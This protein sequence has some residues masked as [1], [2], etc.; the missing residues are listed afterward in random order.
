LKPPREGRGLS[1][2]VFV[3]ALR[4]SL[5]EFRKICPDVKSSFL[6]TRDGVPVAEDAQCNYATM[7]KAVHILQSVAEK[8]STIGGLDTLLIDGDDGRV[9]V[10]SASDMYLTMVTSKDAD[11]LYLSTVTRVIIPT[12]LTLLQ[13]AIPTSLKWG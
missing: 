13:N 3:T 7:E 5:K 6:F 2:D 1:T 10:S 9:Y 11:M 8:A 12:I 4:N